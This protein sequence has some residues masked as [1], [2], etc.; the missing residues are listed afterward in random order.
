MQKFLQ[1]MQRRGRGITQARAADIDRFLSERGR[2]LALKT[3]SRDGYALRAIFRFL[4]VSGRIRH[5]LADIVAVPRMRRGDR[6]PRSL[7]WSDVLRILKAV[8]RKTRSGRRDYALLLVMAVYGLGAGEARGLMLE[9]IDWRRQQLRVVRPKTGRLIY[10]PLLSGVSRSLA[11][12][13][14][15][16]RPRNCTTRAL[17][18]QMHAPYG[19]L[20]SSSAIRHALHKHASCA[21]VSA[22]FMG[23]HVLRHSHACR[24]I[25][26]GT[27]A[28]VVGDILGHRRPE[29]TSVYA[30][31][32][33]RR[34]RALSLPVP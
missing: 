23:S 18:V 26:L 30:R 33:L 4:F 14:Q 5:D 25:D 7:P 15:H 20:R 1:F 11:A 16:G 24:Q 27:S 13:L 9:S 10:L 19:P 22:P 12:Y 21:R 31:V 2:R 28:T 3:L 17:F 32:A 34:L 29:S 6:P 8:D